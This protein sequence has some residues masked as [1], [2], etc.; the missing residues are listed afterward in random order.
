MS[1]AQIYQGTGV[2]VPPQTA[3][4]LSRISK[5]LLN[6]NHSFLINLVNV[7]LLI[8]MKIHLKC[9]FFSAY[10]CLYLVENIN[11]PFKKKKI[12]VFFFFI[13][14]HQMPKK[15]SLECVLIQSPI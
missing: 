10:E 6:Y 9:D 5:L 14:T 7:I 11:M 12:A 2:D 13:S 15:L 4:T 3:P 1:K 8:G